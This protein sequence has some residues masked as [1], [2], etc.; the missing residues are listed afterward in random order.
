MSIVN[1][2]KRCTDNSKLSTIDSKSPESRICVSPCKEEQ[3]S[4]V[5]VDVTVGEEYILPGDSRTYEVPEKGFIIKSGSSVIVRTAECFYLPLNVFG[6]VTGKGSNIFRGCFISTG[7]IDPGFQGNLRI[8]VYN[9][10]RENVIFKRGQALCSV[11]F[12]D[13][14]YALDTAPSSRPASPS[15]NRTKEKWYMKSWSWFK[16]NWY[17]SLAIIVSILSLLIQLLK[18]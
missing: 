1:L 5:A 13:T 7:K 18:K 2:K 14:Q 6:V 10:G 8:G 16:V 12:T 17:S 4:P 3:I 9:G 15:P 11:F